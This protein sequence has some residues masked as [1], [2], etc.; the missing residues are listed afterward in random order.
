LFVF[1]KGIKLL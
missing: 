1:V